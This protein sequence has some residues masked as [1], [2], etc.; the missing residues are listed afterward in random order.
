[1]TRERTLGCAQIW[2]SGYCFGFSIAAALS[3]KYMFLMFL[4]LGAVLQVIGVQN[5]RRERRLRTE[6]EWETRDE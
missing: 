4:P 1:M 6:P 5:I 3:G 2:L